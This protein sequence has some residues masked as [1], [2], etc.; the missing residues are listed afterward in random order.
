MKKIII[1]MSALRASV[2]FAEQ[3]A[4]AKFPTLLGVHVEATLTHTRLSATNGHVGLLQLCVAKNTG[5][6]REDIILP[7]ADLYDVIDES[8]DDFAILIHADKMELVGTSRTVEFKSL[9]GNFPELS[10]V[11]PRRV[12]GELG[13][14]D[15]EYM[16]R[17]AEAARLLDTAHAEGAKPRMTVAHNGTTGAS[18]VRFGDVDNAV[19]IVMA[20]R[21]AAVPLVPPRGCMTPW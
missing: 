12:S 20:L 15:P 7:I 19:G 4:N 17:F 2:L 13:Q 8:T 6:V 16:A 11:V 10:I 1:P 18:L 21:V 9:I 14:F 5:V 3:L